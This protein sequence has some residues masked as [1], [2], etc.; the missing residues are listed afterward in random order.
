[1][2]LRVAPADGEALH[3]YRAESDGSDAPVGLGELSIMVVVGTFVGMGW[4][5]ATRVLDRRQ[6]VCNP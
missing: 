1:M 4:F 2:V 5:V 3:P 6:K